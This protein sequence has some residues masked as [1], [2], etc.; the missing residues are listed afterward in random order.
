[1]SRLTIVLTRMSAYIHTAHVQTQ[2]ARIA[3]RNRQRNYRAYGV[4]LHQYLRH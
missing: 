2:V 3:M 1:M 4:T